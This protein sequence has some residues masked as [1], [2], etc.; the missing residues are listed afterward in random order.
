[1]RCAVQ[2]YVFMGL[3]LLGMLLGPMATAL[4]RPDVGKQGGPTKTAMSST[5]GSII[6]TLLLVR[7]GCGFGTFYVG[8]EI[9]FGAPITY[10]I[11]IDYYRGYFADCLQG[12]DAYL[13]L[14]SAGG[15]GY[16]YAVWGQ[17]GNYV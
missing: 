6:P 4:A 16:T 9:T 1:M 12:A 3:F 11:A 10:S 5:N 2:S 14:R 13:E 8:E 17:M 7:Q 15:A